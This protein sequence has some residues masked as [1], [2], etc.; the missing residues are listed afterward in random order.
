[1][2]TGVML[3]P[4]LGGMVYDRAGYIPVFLMC[5]G[6]IVVVFL[7]RVSIVDRKTAEK[8]VKVLSTVDEA[9]QY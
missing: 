7:L 1:M 5:L 3:S 2:N 6:I 9:D 8:Y 4:F